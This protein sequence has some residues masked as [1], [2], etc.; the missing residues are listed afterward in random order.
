[1]AISQL[2]IKQNLKVKSPIVDIKHR[3]NGVLPAFDSLNKELSPGFCLVD[4][5]P[6]YFSLNIVSHKDVKARTTHLNHLINIYQDSL[7]HPSTAIVIADTGVK[8]NVAT[9]VS[10]IQRKQNIISKAIHYAMNVTSAE[11]ELFAMRC[12][13]S[14]ATQFPGIQRIVITDAIPV[15]RKIFD[16]SIHPYQ[17]H[18][19]AISSD[20]R[21]FF[22]INLTNLI[23]FWD[24]PSDAFYT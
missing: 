7:S 8:N 20:L 24:C 12:S 21:K 11:A 10:H 17:L 22:S 6:N 14:Q 1:M 18:S 16:M 15:A 9:F 3:L 19:I 2:T 5:F 23:S 4:N 13:I